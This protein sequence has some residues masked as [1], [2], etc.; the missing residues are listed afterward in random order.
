MKT[1]IRLF[2]CWRIKNP[3]KRMFCKHKYISEC[4]GVGDGWKG[5]YIKYM[6]K[7]CTKQFKQ[8]GVSKT[9]TDKARRERQKA[10]E[11]KQ[12]YGL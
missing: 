7:N 12:D 2:Y 4:W 10:L 8:M 5:S 1:K 6:C 9:K 11:S 3:I